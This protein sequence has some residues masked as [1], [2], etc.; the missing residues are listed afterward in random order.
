MII[1]E[2]FSLKPFNTFGIEA[3]ARYF[4]EMQSVSDIQIFLNTQYH[5]RKPKLILGGGSNILF[6]KDFEGAV[7]KINTKGILK[8][9]ETTDN[10]FLN[11]QAGEIW[12]DFVNYCLENNY[13]GLE[14]L[15]LIPG[16]VGS[17]PIQN[18]GAY[19][20]EVK[21]Y[22][23]S[24]EL[25]DMQTLQMSELNNKECRFGYRD[26][27]FKQELKG[28]VIIL[29]VT[30]KLTKNHTLH[31]EYGAILE[32]LKK[33]EIKIPTIQ[34]VAQAVC[35][36]RRCKLPDPKEI[37]NAGSTFKNPSVNENIF[38]K[39]KSKF[40]NISSYSQ[41]DGTFKLPAG[42]LI[43]QCEFKGY[44]EGDAG[45]HKNQALVLVNYDNAT[46]EDILNLANKIQKSVA[47][48]FG[49][50]LELEVNVV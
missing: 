40:P 42:W 46:G 50:N 13:G 37:G 43:E 8:I 36:I 45:V 39:L 5:K 15:S 22:I 16:N 35:N 38:T 48:K 23:E 33:N 18:I 26:S 34:T 17:C 14:N 47:V 21:D 11:V 3:E 29:S 32:E 24:V 4:A 6:T 27:I 25:L 2:N 44:R 12:D 10:V 31:L 7:I 30:F 1:V 28:K 20:V 49:I 9:K 19:G 41:P